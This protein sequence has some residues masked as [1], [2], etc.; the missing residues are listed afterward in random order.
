MT[1]DTTDVQALLAGNEE[2]ILNEWLEEAGAGSSRTSDGG[3]RSMRAD[4]EGILRAM[5]QGLQAGGDP[6]SFQAAGWSALRGAL[7]NLSRSRAAAGQ[8]AGDTS[9]FVLA[10][11]RPV[12]KL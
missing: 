12:F 11:K 2:R 4:A 5:R 3:K 10:L 9:A 1:Q 7:E 6:E 8:S